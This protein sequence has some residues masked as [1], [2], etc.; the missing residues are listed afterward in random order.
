MP[1]SLILPHRATP[2]HFLNSRGF[3]LVE[4]VVAIGITVMVLIGSITAA[5]VALRRSSEQVNQIRATFLVEEGI[6]AMRVLRDN[7]WSANIA[8]LATSTNLYLVYDGLSWS[9]TTTLQANSEGLFERI[10]VL[11]DVF[12]GADDDITQS[13]G[14]WDPET[15]LARM[16]VSWRGRRGT[17]TVN[18]STY[19][20]NLFAD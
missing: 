13:G 2:G 18:A 15:K 6:E 19:L 7:G 12:R 16:D 1:I 5:R 3:G 11:S 17:S 4:V 8:G 10:F 14:T 9:A 20:A